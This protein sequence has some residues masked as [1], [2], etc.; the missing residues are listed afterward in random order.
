MFEVAKVIIKA[1]LTRKES[2]GA[3]WR[4]DYREPNNKDWLVNLVV[5]SARGKPRVEITPVTMTKIQ[6]PQIGYHA[7]ETIVQDT[8][9]N[10]FRK[11]HSI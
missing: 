7:L 4:I 6:N 11:V 9:S 3:F 10:C 5:S 2:R 1:S 8:S